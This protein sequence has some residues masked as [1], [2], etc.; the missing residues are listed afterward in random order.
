MRRVAFRTVKM[1]FLRADRSILL[2][3]LQEKNY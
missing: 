3:L 1:L 2:L